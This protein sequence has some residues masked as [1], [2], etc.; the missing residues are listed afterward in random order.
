[1]ETI[2]EMNRDAEAQ[3]GIELNP[4]SR[5]RADPGLAQ[6]SLRFI[7][8]KYVASVNWSV[9]FLNRDVEAALAV[10]SQDIRASFERIVHLIEA[11]R[12]TRM[13]D[14]T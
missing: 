4:A 8:K 2:Q 10:L 11:H 14:P 1:L 7:A 12:L 9:A 5:G 13:R 6:I 3:R